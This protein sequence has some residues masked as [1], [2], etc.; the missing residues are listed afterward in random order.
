M[1][2]RRAQTPPPPATL[3]TTKIRQAGFAESMD[4]EEM[5]RKWFRIFQEMNLLLPRSR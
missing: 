1:H 4:T 5:F 2:Q 3:S